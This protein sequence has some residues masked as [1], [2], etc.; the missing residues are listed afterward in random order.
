MKYEDKELLKAEIA[1]YIQR[2]NYNKDGVRSKSVRLISDVADEF[3]DKREGMRLL[4]NNTYGLLGN[5]LFKYVRDGDQEIN[6]YMEE[7]DEKLIWDAYEKFGEE[8]YNWIG[9]WRVM[10]VILRKEPQL[11]DKLE[12]FLV[13][14]YIAYEIAEYC[15]GIMK[16]VVPRIRK[17][18]DFTRNMIDINPKCLEHAFWCYKADREIVYEAMRK[19]PE[20]IC[21]TDPSLRKDKELV[22]MAVRHRG[23]L[24]SYADD[25]LKDDEDIVRAAVDN[26]GLALR[27]ASERL[28][29]DDELIRL[30]E[31]S[32]RRMG[33]HQ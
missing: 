7:L 10:K 29:H 14:P 8:F 26:N 5:L 33:W 2:E 9:T 22:E 13:D 18:R 31:D 16:N 30:A 17:E 32:R 6:D 23:L 1:K 24:L 27:F 15:P 3:R 21:F 12:W 11:V 20:V 4:L 28:Q 19:D 25:T